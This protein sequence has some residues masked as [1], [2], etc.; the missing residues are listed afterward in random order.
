MKLFVNFFGNIPVKCI[1]S[2]NNIRII[3]FIDSFY[4][5][6]KLIYEAR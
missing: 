4:V 3:E 5:L 2:K 6:K 1:V